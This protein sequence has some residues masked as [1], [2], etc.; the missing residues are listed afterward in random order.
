MNGLKCLNVFPWLLKLGMRRR[1]A[2]AAE[3]K[4][5]VSIE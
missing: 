3:M 4:I 1:K 5:N 2:Y